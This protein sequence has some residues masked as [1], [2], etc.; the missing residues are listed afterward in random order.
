MPS[1]EEYLTHLEYGVKTCPA[2]YDAFLDDDRYETHC[3]KMIR[4]LCEHFRVENEKGLQNIYLNEPYKFEGLKP[5]MWVW[6]NKVKVCCQICDTL[7]FNKLSV[8]FHFENIL[9]FEEN[10]FYP[11]QMANEDKL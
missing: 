3:M 7:S 10:R 5:N 11:V 4:N 6:D 2:I 1:K 8:N 9:E